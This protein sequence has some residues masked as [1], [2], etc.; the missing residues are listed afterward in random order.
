MTTEPRMIF[1]L[2]PAFGNRM[3]RAIARD[4]LQ[5]FLDQKAQ[6]LSRSIVEHLRWDLNNILKTAM[7]DG[8]TDSNPAAGLFTPPCKAEAEKLTMTAKQI[9][10]ALNALDLRERVLFRMSVFDGM[11]PGEVCSATIRT[12]D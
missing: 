12:P 7:S 4:E 6:T 10:L 1:H 11:R 5:S 8:L 2:K 9:L 3:I